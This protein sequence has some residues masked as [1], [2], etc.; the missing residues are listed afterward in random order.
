M[1]VDRGIDLALGTGVCAIG[2]WMGWRLSML[3]TEIRRL[4]QRVETLERRETVR[5]NPLREVA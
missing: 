5:G 2:G 3:I 1:Y 4:R